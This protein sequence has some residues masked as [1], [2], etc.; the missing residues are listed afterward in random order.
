MFRMCG[1]HLARSRLAGSKLLGSGVLA[2]R[3]VHDLQ[4]MCLYNAKAK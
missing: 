4:S 3:S 1:R 2:M